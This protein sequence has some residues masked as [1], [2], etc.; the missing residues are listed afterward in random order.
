MMNGDKEL[1]YLE[2]VQ[3]HLLNCFSYSRTFLDASVGSKILII[4]TDFDEATHS[5]NLIA[6]AK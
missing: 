4:Q 3:E 5:S 1:L 2:S 6:S